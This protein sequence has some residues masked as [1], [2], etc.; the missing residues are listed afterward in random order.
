LCLVVLLLLRQLVRPA[1]VPV[2]WAPPPQRGLGQPL[3]LRPLLLRALLR[4]PLLLLVA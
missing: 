3:L 4:M 2:G 1:R